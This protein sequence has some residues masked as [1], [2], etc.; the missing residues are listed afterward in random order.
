M[1]QARSFLTGLGHKKR[2]ADALSEFGVVTLKDLVNPKKVT[3]AM[4]MSEAVAMTDKE[5]RCCRLS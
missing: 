2:V 5:V 4:L 3:D 1:D